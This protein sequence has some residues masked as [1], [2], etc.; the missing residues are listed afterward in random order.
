MDGIPHKKHTLM[1][2]Q[3]HNSVEKKEPKKNTYDKTI[4]IKSSCDPR[5]DTN[6]D[7]LQTYMRDQGV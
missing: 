6:C 4:F 7:M 5:G 2:I 3:D 1:D